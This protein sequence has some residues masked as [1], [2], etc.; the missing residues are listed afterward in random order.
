MKDGEMREGEA[1]VISA[2]MPN[3][4][5]LSGGFLM[6]ACLLLCERGQTECVE[7]CVAGLN[8]DPLPTEYVLEQKASGMKRKKAKKGKWGKKKD[9]WEMRKVPLGIHFVPS[10][11]AES[12]QES[13]SVNNSVSQVASDQLNKAATNCWTDLCF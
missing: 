13:L 4:S 8:S 11:K 6:N 7:V 12:L 1:K 9:G 3:R 2:T 10:G 5:Q